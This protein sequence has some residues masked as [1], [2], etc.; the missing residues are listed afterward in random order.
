MIKITY[1][2]KDYAYIPSKSFWVDSNNS[3]VH[4]DEVRE[5][6]RQIAVESGYTELDF[7]KPPSPMEHFKKMLKKETEPKKKRNPR[8]KSSSAVSLKNILKRSK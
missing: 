8:L 1:N 7:V 6:L 3:I 4:S 2:E 5:G